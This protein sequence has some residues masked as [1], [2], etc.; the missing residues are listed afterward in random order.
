LHGAFWDAISGLNSNFGALGYGIVG[1]FV[2]SWG[3]SYLIYRCKGYDLAV[4]ID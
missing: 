4:P 1:L 2:V 3:V